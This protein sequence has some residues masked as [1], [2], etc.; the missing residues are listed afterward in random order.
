LLLALP[1]SAITSTTAALLV[2]EVLITQL[3][4]EL[5]STAAAGA[6]PN[7]NTVAAPGAKPLPVTVTL[8]PPAIGPAF[9]LTAVIVGDSNLKWS[10]VEMALVPLGVVT[11]M[12]TVPLLAAGDS[13][14]I[15]LAELT[16]K[17]LAGLDPKSTAVAPLKLLPL[18]VSEV[19]PSA[20][21]LFAL[22]LV[23]VGG[24]T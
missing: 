16:V 11:L 14:V 2:A 23:S 1:T 8:V 4:V 3:V 12:S 22:T 7:S 15:E 6:L 5:Q 20:G 19:P 9:G 10:L 18:M 17:L 24:G 21:P 13:A